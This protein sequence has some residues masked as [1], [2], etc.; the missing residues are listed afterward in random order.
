MLYMDRADYKKDMIKKYNP[1][2]VIFETLERQI[3]TLWK[4]EF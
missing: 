2:I 4:F 3:E 1:N